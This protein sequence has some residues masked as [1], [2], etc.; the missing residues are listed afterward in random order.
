M[1]P[2]SAALPPELLRAVDARCDAFEE[3]WLR[4]GR[5][6]LEEYL[7]G[8]D[9]A[10]RPALLGELIRVELVWRCRRGDQPAAADYV[11]RFP[12][13]AGAIDTWL[14]EALLSARAGSADRPT[15]AP[16]SVA[17]TVQRPPAPLPALLGEYELL[18][19]LGGGGMGE[20]F[21]ARH[22]RLDKLVAVKLL[23]RRHA[24][25][26]EAVARFLREMK[27]LGRLEHPNVAEALD[28]GEHEGTVFLVMKL[29]EGTDLRRLVEERGPLPVAEACELIRQAALGLHYLHER[30]LVHRDL[31]PSNLMRTPEGMVKILDLG[32]ARGQGEAQE[33]TG[34]GQVLGTPD[35]LAPEQASG[36]TVD[37]RSDL[38]AL[39]GTL[40]TLLTGRAPFAHHR[41]W[42]RKVRAQEAE[43]PP[44]V[45][46]LRPEVPA[47]LAELLTRL[48]AKHP[49]DRPQ[50]AAQV[51]DALAR[52]AQ[53]DA[54][55]FSWTPVPAQQRRWRAVA[56]VTVG[57][58]GLLVLALA[59]AHS[60]GRRDAPG[61]DAGRPSAT[62][63]R[64]VQAKKRPV[65]LRVV[66]LD[67]KHF[68][69]VNGKGDR[70]TGSLGEQVFVARLDDSVELH[71]E[72]SRPGYAYLIAFRPDGTEQVCFPQKEDQAPPRTDRPRYPWA[73][74]TAEN[75]GLNEGTGLQAFA[76]VASSRPL[77]AYR[78]WRAK[79]GQSVWGKHQA[80]AGVIWYDDGAVVEAWTPTGK[81][82][83]QRGTGRQRAGKAAL[84]RL[85]DWLRRGPEVEA[86]AV[87]GFAVLAK[88]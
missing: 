25:A 33:L 58:L 8:A 57:V 1:S 72:L 14:A 73:A 23:A 35:Y 32:L 82:R 65:A 71:G 31:K 34:P 29:V 62:R 63:P 39:G 21:K 68:E 9:E 17:E 5:P 40:F 13:C 60:E 59:L 43:T 77:P 22:R 53:S 7:K 74:R 19:R 28:A 2:S 66:R 30:D 38:Y 47:G 48:L 85:T 11:G 61:S 69:N 87:L 86:V 80:P 24:H 41:E 42:L 83:S 4:G 76:L 15:P 81:Q 18:E 46:T 20:V 51:A 50:S 52:W 37:G 70:P 84:I 64:L 3:A 27:A 67:V 26:P 79:L 12:S 75:Y 55:T 16:P 44:D 6:V 54:A 56:A 88:E 78:E 10:V 36:A 49:A 45:R